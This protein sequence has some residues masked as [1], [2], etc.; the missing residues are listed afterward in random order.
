MIAMVDTA[1]SMAMRPEIRGQRGSRGSDRLE[2]AILAGYD[3]K[4]DSVASSAT[5]WHQARQR[6]IKRDSVA[7][8]ATSRHQGDLAARTRPAGRAMRTSFLR[9]QGSATPQE[10]RRAA[11]EDGPSY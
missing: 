11:P 3:I 2:I 1:P 8:S 10:R 4:R 6:G 9:S 5:A 7:S